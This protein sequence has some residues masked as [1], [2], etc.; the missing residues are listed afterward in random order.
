MLDYGVKHN[1][2][3]EDNQGLS[4]GLKF[5]YSRDLQS[6]LTSGDFPLEQTHDCI[7]R[8]RRVQQMPHLGGG[9]NTALFGLTVQTS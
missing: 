1:N 4:V 7:K 5:S 6:V 2:I 9:T 8:I 3:I